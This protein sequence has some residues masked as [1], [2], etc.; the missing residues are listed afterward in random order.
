MGH[1][2]FTMKYA[3]TEIIHG[4]ETVVTVLPLDMVPFFDPKNPPQENTYGVPDA[5]Q[6]GWV[7]DP[8]T[9]KFVQS[10]QSGGV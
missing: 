10:I 2:G 8:A 4:V 1:K 9:G 5:V 7:K 3:N 6:V